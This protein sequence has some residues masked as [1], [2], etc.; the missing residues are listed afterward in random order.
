M[1]RPCLVL[2]CQSLVLSLSAAAAAARLR[3]KEEQEEQRKTDPR[4]DAVKRQQ[5]ICRRAKW[6]DKCGLRPEQAHFLRR[7]GCRSHPTLRFLKKLEILRLSSTHPPSLPPSA[8]CM[9]SLNRA[10]TIAPRP[11]PKS[12]Q[13][14]KCPLRGHQLRAPFLESN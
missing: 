2:R 11:A 1:P 8:F 4:S 12:T 14:P 10:T 7:Q 5:R 3:E 13:R 9:I 6:G